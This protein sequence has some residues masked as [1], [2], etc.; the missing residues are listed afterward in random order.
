MRKPLLKFARLHGG[1]S[2]IPTKEGAGFVGEGFRRCGDRERGC[3]AF[4]LSFRIITPLVL[5]SSLVELDKS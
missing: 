4:N 5:T 3:H 2:G 1:K